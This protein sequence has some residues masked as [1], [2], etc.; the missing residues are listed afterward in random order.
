MTIINKIAGLFLLT[1]ITAIFFNCSSSVQSLGTNR[2]TLGY[3]SAIHKDLLALPKPKEKIVIAVYKFRD[4]TGQYKAAASGYTWS[5]AVTQGATSMVLKALED[6]GWFVTVEREGI[7]NLLNERKIIRS[8]RENYTDGNGQA[9]PPL[10]PLLYAGV[11]MEGGIISYETNYVTGGFGAKYFGLGGSTEFRKDMVTIYLRTVATKSGRILNTVNTTKTILSKAVDL[12]LYRFVREKRLLEMEAGITTNEPPNMC[13]LEAIEKA[14][15][16]L[17][18]EGI[19]ASNWELENP[20]DIKSPIIQ[21]YLSEKES[22]ERDVKFDA[23]GYLYKNNPNQFSHT[24]G[25][26]FGLNIGGAFLPG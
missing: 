20:E 24:K 9:L 6:S 23:E 19:L 5:T 11:T 3:T 2:A 13:V 17:I 15:F 1:L 22:V 4:Q 8:T 26:S 16:S 14:V 21:K 12:N 10:P 7:S 25:V 18:V